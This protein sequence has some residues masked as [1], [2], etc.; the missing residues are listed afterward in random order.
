MGAPTL[1]GCAGALFAVGVLAAFL[2][3]PR[4]LSDLT[5]QPPREAIPPH[6]SCKDSITCWLQPLSWQRLVQSRL[7]TRL[8]GLAKPDRDRLAAA[9]L[10]EAGLAKLDPLFVLALIEVESG[11]DPRALSDRGAQG[12]M[13]LRP[14]TLRHEAVR[15]GL[16]G[17]DPSDPVLNVMAGVRYYKRLL[18]IFKSQD[19]A[20]MAY[21]AG[22]NRITGYLRSGGV[23]ER[24]HSFP[25]RVRSEFKRLHKALALDPWDAVA[26]RERTEVQPEEAG[27]E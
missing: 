7:A 5:I 16:S 25:R 17:D 12:L 19:L 15:S 8:P 24:F 27:L 13:Q 22:P 4:S 6:P 20:L 26:A 21:N 10:E 23:P 9:I 1:R 2:G 18:Q 11:Y 3:A 14:S